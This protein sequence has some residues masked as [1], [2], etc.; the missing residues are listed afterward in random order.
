MVLI[1]AQTDP[2][3]KHLSTKKTPFENLFPPRGKP[4]KNFQKT[5]AKSNKAVLNQN[6]IQKTSFKISFDKNSVIVIKS[7]KILKKDT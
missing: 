4:C 3:L 5:A 1:S 2:K 7:L 6:W